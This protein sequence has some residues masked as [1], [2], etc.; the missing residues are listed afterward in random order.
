MLSEHELLLKNWKELEYVLYML[1]LKDEE[2][3]IWAGRLE[4]TIRDQ[5][6]VLG[7]EKGDFT[8]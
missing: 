8:P 3:K 5:K 6:K 1:N 2:C 7:E 4:I